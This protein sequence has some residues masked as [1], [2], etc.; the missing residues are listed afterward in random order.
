MD[1]YVSTGYNVVGLTVQI[2]QGDVEKSLYMAGLNAG[3][4][5]EIKAAIQLSGEFA[6]TGYS[7]TMRDKKIKDGTFLVPAGTTENYSLSKIGLKRTVDIGGVDTEMKTLYIPFMIP[8]DKTKKQAIATQLIGKTIAGA[9]ITDV[10]QNLAG[11][12]GA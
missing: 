3:D 5:D 9:K 1:N 10:V 6:V 8:E 12:M 7:L 11:S 2:K 4:F